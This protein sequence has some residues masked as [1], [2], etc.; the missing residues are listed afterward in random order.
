MQVI[1]IKTYQ[2]FPRDKEKGKGGIVLKAHQHSFEVTVICY[3]DCS[4]NFLIIHI[5]LR[6]TNYF[7]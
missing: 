7:F 1:I 4:D 5:F 6:L 2:C 3:V